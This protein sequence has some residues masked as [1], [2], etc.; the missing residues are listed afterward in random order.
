M[1]TVSEIKPKQ[2]NL[3][4]FVRGLYSLQ[5]LRI[6]MGNRI[7]ANFKVKLGQAPGEDEE[8]LSD[9]AKELLQRLRVSYLKITDGVLGATI[10]K[11]KFVSDG[12]IS[13]YTE[14]CLIS[15]Y[16]EIERHEKQH[17]DRLKSILKD[18]P[19][20]EKFLLE[21]KGCGPA[22]AAV[23]ISEIDIHK[24][25]YPSSLWKY[26]GLDVVAGWEL[27]S[28]D[29]IDGVPLDQVEGRIP[30]IDPLR[31][32]HG[33][34]D[35]V[36]TDPEHLSV[37]FVVG[38]KKVKGVYRWVSSGG[39]SRRQEHLVERKYIDAEGKEHMRKSIAFRPFLKTKLMGVLADAFLRAG[40]NKYEQE[41][42]N[43]K[44]RIENMPQWK[45]K[46]KGHRHQAAKR[47]A[48]KRFLVD[49]YV[50]WRQLEGLPVSEEY[51]A[52]KLGIRHRP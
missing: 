3:R 35:V 11:S 50:A 21:V 8:E 36:A 15:N 37:T 34:T 17:F 13:D 10:K 33:G 4:T 41:Y 44:N 24:A 51:S 12:V 19:I 30:T 32:E 7:V 29:G 9:D 49:L 25:R 27:H 28:V 43:Y 45:D 20:Y 2:E 46:S 5:K 26:T 16:M 40:E 1:T 38:G 47:Y 39:R 48:V 52:G 22:M 42:R 18:F 23:I 14:F 31:P 6:Q